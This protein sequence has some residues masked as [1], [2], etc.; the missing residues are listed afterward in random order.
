MDTFSS[1]SIIRDLAT[2]KKLNMEMGINQTVTLNMVKVCLY[3]QVI[4]GFLRI[5]RQIHYGEGECHRIV[6]SYS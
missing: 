5:Q 2:L 3:I 4:L 1:L 6:I